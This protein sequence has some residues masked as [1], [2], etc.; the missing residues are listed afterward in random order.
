MIL[1]PTSCWDQQEVEKLGIVLGTALEPGENGNLRVIVQVLNPKGLV[2]NAGQGSGGGAGSGDMAYRNVSSEGITIFDAVRKLN[3]FTPKELYF[4]HNQVIIISEKL[5]RENITGLLDFFDRNP[6][7]R[8][9]NWILISKANEEQG[10]LLDIAS[11]LVI[12]PTERIVAI[13]NQR[14]RSPV[15]AVNQLGDFLELLAN[16]GIDAFTAGITLVANPG[17]EAGNSKREIALE[18]TAVFRDGKLVGWLNDRESRG[19]LWTKEG[20]D[21]GI[22]SISESNG[23]DVTLEIIRSKSKL[24]A[25]VSEDGQITLQVEIKA[26]AGLTETMHYMDIDDPKVIARLE[27]LLAKE[28][29]KDIQL[30]LEKSQQYQS[31]VLGVGALIHRQYP[32]YWREIS[33]RWAEY[34][35]QVQADVSANVV[36]P[37]TGLISKPV[38]ISDEEVR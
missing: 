22:Y 33:D 12:A 7:I 17:S 24:N 36:I 28:I 18:N 20:L 29:E 38:K 14:H 27:A 8:R 34:Y 31:D 6:Q 30:V 25:F 13:I 10:E 19:L 2:G 9:N 35:P 11:P 26:R 23:V 37:R 4:A 1:V 32:E 15:Y 21:G 3:V 5:A 16:E